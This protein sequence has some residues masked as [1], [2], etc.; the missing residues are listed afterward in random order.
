MHYVV[1]IQNLPLWD[2][3]LASYR[4]VAAQMGRAP[5]VRALWH[6]TTHPEPL[7]TIAH[8]PQGFDLRVA[9]TNGKAFGHGVYFHRNACYA[10]GHAPPDPHCAHLKHLVLSLVVVGEPCGG[11]AGMTRPDPAASGAGQT[12]GH[13][14]DTAADS[15]DDPSRFVVFESG[16]SLAYPLYTVAYKWLEQRCLAESE[17]ESGRSSVNP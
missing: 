9:T 8:T 1:R 6:G 11:R 10:D 12:G 16:G 5:E 4:V 14:C 2:R 15:I 3:F 13:I 17:S 7:R